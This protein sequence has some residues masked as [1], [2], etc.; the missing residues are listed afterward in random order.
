MLPSGKLKW[1]DAASGYLAKYAN[2]F[3]I[4]PAL[5]AVV[6]SRWQLDYSSMAPDE[7]WS[8]TFAG[9]SWRKLINV[10]WQRELNM[11][12]YYILLKIWIAIFGD[13]ELAVRSLSVVFSVFAVAMTFAIGKKL[14]DAKTGLVAASLLAVNAFLIEYAQE[15]RSYT[16]LIFMAN[17]SVYFFINMIQDQNVKNHVLYVFSSVLLVY[18]HFFGLFILIVQAIS[19]IFFAGEK[20]NYR[21]LLLCALSIALLIIPI[22]YFILFKDNGQI[23]WIQKPSFKDLYSFMFSLTGD[24]GSGMLLSLYVL[25]F[26]IS[27]I[28]LARKNPESRMTGSFGRHAFLLVWLLLPVIAAYSFSFYKPIFISKY[29]IS[30]LTPLVLLVATGL[31]A[32]RSRWISTVAA[33]GL[34]SISVYTVFDVYYPKQKFDWKSATRYISQNARKGDGIT[35]YDYSAKVTFEYYHRILSVEKDKLESVYPSP[36]GIHS[37]YPLGN[38]DIKSIDTMHERYNRLWCVLDLEMH[39]EFE[40]ED[41]PMIDKLKEKYSINRSAIYKGVKIFLLEK[42]YRI[43]KT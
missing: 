5:F 34:I 26:F 6:L 41:C 3:F 7:A 43:E 33:F 10:M 31:S 19:L 2:Y 29:L 18:S 20:V 11:G 40:T 27:L 8:I 38:P 23:G 12:P 30:S 39:P 16:L 28:M 35:F 17:T 36:L 24:G 25:M 14:F 21:R 32:I 9:L 22:G 42:P 37:F 13:S 1:N 4:I 15:A